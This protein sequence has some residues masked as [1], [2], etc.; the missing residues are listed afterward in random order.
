MI[1]HKRRNLLI[2]KILPGILLAIVVM[3][4]FFPIVNAII[5]SLKMPLHIW[6]FPPRFF[7]PFYSLTNY[8]ELVKDW[9]Q[10]FGNLV[11]SLIVTSG[12]A[13][14]VI[15][16]SIF[17]AYAFS[18][19]SHRLVRMSTLFTII[20][21]MIPPIIVVIPLFP[22]FNTF[23][24]V[25]KHI[26]LIML[27]A[28]FMVSITTLL[29]KTFVDDVP[30]ALEE[31]A[32][33]DGCSR[34]QAFLKITIPLSAPGIVAAVIFTAIFAWNEYLFAF[35][36][37]SRRAATAPLILSEFMGS[38]MGVEWGMLLAA[39]VIHLIPMLILTWMVQSY[40][41]KGMSFGAVKQ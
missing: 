37:T 25:D 18:R 26:T 30:V 33:I 24:L 34:F 27:Y 23:G 21:R 31:A 29:M 8:Q 39:A 2:E 14:V 20:I 19:F 36:F 4:A 13:L 32:L 35:I 38:F 1:T 3:W 10:Y 28:A 5:G 41:I 17:G 16:C 6:D 11:N 12:T 7:G 9:P 15:L 22:I 40:L